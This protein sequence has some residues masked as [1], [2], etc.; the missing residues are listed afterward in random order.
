[1]EYFGVFKGLLGNSF[2]L[3]SRVTVDFSNERYILQEESR[4]QRDQ[5]KDHD[6][7]KT[8]LHCSR[9]RRPTLRC[10]GEVMQQVPGNTAADDRPHQC[11]A[12]SC[13]YLPQVASRRRTNA[14]TIGWHHVLRDH[15]EGEE[16]E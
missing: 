4:G 11:D 15:R 7:Y 12:Q 3:H 14:W 1:M 9:Q 5:R 10:R 13:P 8:V 6:R 2:S 16:R